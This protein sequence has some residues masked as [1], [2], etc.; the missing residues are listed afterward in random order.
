MCLTEFEVCKVDIP[1][2][3]REDSTEQV[4][5]RPTVKREKTIQVAIMT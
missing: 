3:Q 5:Q 4:T 2:G 1:K